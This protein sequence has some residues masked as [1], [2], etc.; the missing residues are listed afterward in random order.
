MKAI[1]LFI[2][3]F[4]LC[5]A[6]TLRIK[7][8]NFDCK[9]NELGQLFVSENKKLVYQLEVPLDG[10]AAFNLP[11][12]QYDISYITKSGCSATLNHTHQANKDSDITI[13]VKQ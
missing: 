5:S 2:T 3:P 10:S 12:G 9:T 7:A 6:S 1:I 11:K 8:K 4:F 13:E